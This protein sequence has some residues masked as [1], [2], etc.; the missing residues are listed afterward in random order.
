[1]NGLPTYIFSLEMHTAHC[2]LSEIASAARLDFKIGQTARQERRSSKRLKI[3]LLFTRRYL[4]NRKSYRDEWEG[5]SKRKV[6]RFYP[7]FIRWPEVII[8]EVMAVQRFPNFNRKW[9]KIIFSLNDISGGTF[10]RVSFSASNNRPFV[11]KNS[12]SSKFCKKLKPFLILIR[13][14]SNLEDK[15]YDTCIFISSTVTLTTISIIK[16]PLNQFTEI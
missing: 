3:T 10:Q 1:M 8:F 2:S 7:S 15:L 14:Q 5:V 13:V 6:L 12:L 4:G 11:Q 16:E 9:L